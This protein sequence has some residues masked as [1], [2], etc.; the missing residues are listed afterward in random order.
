MLRTPLIEK[1]L[2][3]AEI[4]KILVEKLLNGYEKGQAEGESINITDSSNLPM[5]LSPKGQII[6][7]TRAGYNFG[8]YDKETT[9]QNEV[10][11]TH[12]EDESMNVNG[13]SNNY[14][15]FVLNKTPVKLE[16]GTYTFAYIQDIATTGDIH[17]DIRNT[18]GNPLMITYLNA[19]LGTW[20]VK[21]LIL[22]ETTEVNY[23][24]YISNGLSVNNQNFKYMLLKGTYTVEDLPEYEAFGKMP[25]T[26]FPSPTKNVE[27]DYKIENVNSNLYDINDLSEKNINIQIDK[28]DWISGTID[29]SGGSGY[30]FLNFFSRKKDYI[31]A[32]KKYYVLLEVKKVSGTGRLS[33]SSDFQGSSQF[34]S[35]GYNFSNLKS[36]SKYLSEITT[37]NDFSK[38]IFALRSYL[39]FQ[40]GESGSITFRLSLLN[41]KPDLEKFI[42]K[43]HDSKILELNIPKQIK[44]YNKN[45]GFIY[46]T[47]EQATELELVDGEGWY[48]YNEWGEI[49]IVGTERFI[50]IESIRTPKTYIYQFDYTKL[51]SPTNNNVIGAKCNYFNENTANNIWSTKT[52][53]EAFSLNINHT[54]HIRTEIAPDLFKTWLEEKN[55]EGNPLKVIGKLVN[56]TYTK[57]TDKNFIKQLEELQK[58]F[59]HEGINNI[60]TCSTDD[61]DKSPLILNVEYLKSQKIINKNLETRLTALENALINNI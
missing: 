59:S 16:A 45:D 30:V 2:N 14:T 27:G 36:N 41:N 39:Q 20:K 18:L 8:K 11:F 60:D 24:Y 26:N 37:I 13:T 12:N 61:K 54:L 58:A 46:L 51:M 6:Q 34:T 53:L 15:T 1:I 10:T 17:F 38:T 42:Y 25:S 9:T 50:E 32:N 35:F 47:E 48:V 7:D 22:E 33:I 3:T 31:K 23:V 49:V 21:E 19:G 29:N 44:L 43:K 52:D 57:I 56:P 28:D 4:N 5:I 55:T 40:S